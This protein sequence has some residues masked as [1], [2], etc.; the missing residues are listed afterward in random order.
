MIIPACACHHF[1]YVGLVDT[2]TTG[3][4]VKRVIGSETGSIPVKAIHAVEEDYCGKF[5]NHDKPKFL[6]DSRDCF[7]LARLYKES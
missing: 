3:V 7:R 4:P 5:R 6:A 1:A 2:V